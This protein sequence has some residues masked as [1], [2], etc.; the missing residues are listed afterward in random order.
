MR[1]SK[2][3]SPRIAYDFDVH[4]VNSFM[5]VWTKNY[6]D[7][8]YIAAKESGI[9]FKNKTLLD[10]GIGRGRSLVVFKK[11]GIKKVVGIEVT[12][13][14]A[15]FAKK[16]AKRVSLPLQLIIDNT[17]NSKLKKIP[18][19]SIEVIGLMNILFCLPNDK[20]RQTIIKEVKRLLKPHGALIVLDMQK[21]SLMWF[22]SK[23]TLKKWKFRSDEEVIRLFS[24]LKLVI[25]K[26][27]N[28]FYF[29][30]KLV[31]IVSSIVGDGFVYYFDRVFRFLHI[32]PSTKTFIFTKKT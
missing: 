18:S 11:L 22:F 5:Y 21:P 32:P 12:D 27:S 19:N 8:T 29:I 7:A 24:P 25:S 3:L 2:S 17:D 15:A 28:F 31:D 4:S 16:Q 13:S 10:I 9:N 20:S 6:M 26:P 23:I 30:N 1:K 14:E